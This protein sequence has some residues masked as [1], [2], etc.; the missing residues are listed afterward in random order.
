MATDGVQIIDGDLA[1]DTYENIMELYDSGANAETIKKE[2]PFI[3]DD[4]GIN[5]DFYHEIFVTAYAL[6][7]WEIGELT[8]EILNEVKRVI[9]LK[10]GVKLWTEEC[11]EKEGKKRL[12]VLDKFL[13]NIS[14]PNQKIRKRKKYRVVKNLHFEQND[15]LTFCLPDDNY[16]AV[17]CANI[18][19]DKSQTTYELAITTYKRK[20]KPTINLLKN[21]FIVG[22]IMGGHGRSKK[23]F[24]EK[25]PEIDILWEYHKNNAQPM[26]QAQKD[27][28]YDDS[29]I[30]VFEGREHFAFGIPFEF[31]T[32]KDMTY[33]KD[34]FEVIGKL[35]IKENFNRLGGI[36]Y[37]STFEEFED[38]FSDIDHY[39]EV[40]MKVKFPVKL[41]CEID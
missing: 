40:F 11:D 28:T 1:H 31:V 23:E 17:I 16:C 13:Q 21:E 12:K 27:R 8:D 7:F 4:Y 36:S 3:K 26:T 41:L 15:V 25:Q 33:M 22:H 29:F 34:R 14:E 32:H 35:K 30:E 37:L 9:D 6:A 38:F 10:A 20:D 39:I 19:Q 5:S 2:Y 18:T 24:L